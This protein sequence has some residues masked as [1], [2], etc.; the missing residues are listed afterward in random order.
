MAG[1]DKFTLPEVINQFN[2]YD[3]DGNR[4]IGITGEMSLAEIKNIMASVSGSGISGSYNVPVVGHFESI[5]QE[6]PFRTLYVNI[7][8]LL[9]PMKLQTFNI[10]GAIQAT[11]ISTGAAKIVGFRYL[12]KG[13]SSGLNPGNLNNGEVMGTK[14]PIEVTYVL[15][16]IGGKPFFELDKVNGVYRVDGKDLLAEVRRL[17]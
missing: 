7:A 4:H 2:V 8:E 11:N 13:R 16:E 17:C 15:I 12:L 10:R 14:V 5:T 6:I 3:G 9:N 1:Y